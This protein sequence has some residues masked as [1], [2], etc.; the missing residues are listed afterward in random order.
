MIKDVI[1]DVIKDMIEMS[2]VQWI[3][4]NVCMGGWM[5][6]RPPLSLSL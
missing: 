2:M 5:V 6:G 1:K 4:V 3:D